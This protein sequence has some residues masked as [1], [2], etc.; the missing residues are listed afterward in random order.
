MMEAF[1]SDYKVGFRVPNYNL[2][3][4]IIGRNGKSKK[5]IETETNSTINI[6]SENYFTITGDTFDTVKNAENKILSIIIA[7]TFVANLGSSFKS[8]II[9]VGG[10]NVKEL[11]KRSGTHI[12]FNNDQLEV[13]GKPQL[14]KTAKRGIITHIEKK[15]RCQM[16]IE[17]TRRNI[18]R[19]NVRESS[20]IYVENQLKP[21]QQLFFLDFKTQLTEN[22]TIY[23]EREAKA[24]IKNQPNFISKNSGILTPY[25]GYLCRAKV[26]SIDKSS[27][28]EDLQLTVVFVDFGNTGLVS[29]FDCEN[30]E[31]QYLYPPAATPC[32]LYNIKQNAWGKKS[33]KL[34]QQLL[35]E[36]TCISKVNLIDTCD[37]RL[38]SINVT[39]EAIGDIGDHLVTKGDAKWKD[40]P[41]NPNSDH[42]IGNLT[43]AIDIVYFMDGDG[44]G[45]CSRFSVNLSTKHFDKFTRSHKLV[46]EEM[47]SGMENAYIFSEKFLKSNG[48]LMLENYSLHFSLQSKTE[49]YGGSIG[50]AIV[51]AIVSK[52]LDWDIPNDIAITGEIS[53]TGEVTAVTKLREKVLAAHDHGKTLLYVPEANLNEALEIKTSVMVKPFKAVFDV[54]SEIWTLP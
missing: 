48:C 45:D 35:N 28:G 31:S 29:Y 34:F 54:I 4:I 37:D 52:G 10:E 9:G 24:G 27:D 40:D 50:A 14:L 38:V 46:G 22:E 8:E 21:S 53:S 47:L 5:L 20:P 36:T 12:K 23:S 15:I 39:V 26:F 43:G 41:F 25:E 2:C 3:R 18:R 33:L 7:N 32:Q 6:D 19:E 11:Q 17:N 30:L 42:K 51:L 13:I 1:F 49:V 16:K 44:Y